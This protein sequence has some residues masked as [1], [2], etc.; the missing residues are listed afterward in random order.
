MLLVLLLRILANFI[1][2]L[3]EEVREVEQV[4]EELGEEE[5]RIGFK[6]EEELVYTHFDEVAYHQQIRKCNNV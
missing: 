2:L 5:A 6:C 4:V 1:E 3:L